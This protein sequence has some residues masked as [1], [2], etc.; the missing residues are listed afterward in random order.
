MIKRVI[1]NK[2]TRRGTERSWHGAG[3]ILSE[4]SYHGYVLGTVNWLQGRL[5]FRIDVNPRKCNIHKLI[6]CSG[7]NGVHFHLRHCLI[8]RGKQQNNITIKELKTKNYLKQKML[9]SN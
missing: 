6:S 4:A 2:N 5:A 9:L 8:Q 7:N 1:K 3:F